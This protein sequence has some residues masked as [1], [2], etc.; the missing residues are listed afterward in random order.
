M[1]NLIDDF[2][3][4][5]K[6]ALD[7]AVKPVPWEPADSLPFFLR[8][9]YRFYTFPLSDVHCLLMAAREQQEQTP[10][11]VRKHL[12]QVRKHCDAEVI[13]LHPLVSAYNRKRLIEHK[14]PFVV[15]GNQMYLPMLGFD[16]REHF[17]KSRSSGSVLSPA[18]QTLVLHGL[19]NENEKTFT[20]SSVAAG[21]GYTAMTLTR[22][23]NEL[24]SVGLAEVFLQGRE[25]MLR[26][27]WTKRELWENAKAFMRSPVRK[28]TYI[29]PPQQAWPGLTAG[30]TALAHYTLL[31]PPANP[32]YA[33]GAADFKSLK[34]RRGFTEI[35]G[36]KEPEICEIEIWSYP[37]DLFSKGKV[38]D[39]FSL[40]LSLR[41][42]EDERVEAALEEM[43]EA[44]AW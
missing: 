18:T 26:F 37:P 3:R 33:M 4:Y 44:I 34:Q 24:E 10:A 20:P 21:L 36:P 5:L 32:V 16:L 28:R 6:E 9:L 7:V 17:R 29:K 25:R 19:F 42:S 8:D 13:Y 11:I 40:Y 41:K 12:E 27:K 1:E 35:D 15:P 22:A 39:R 30:L 14:V 23:F 43:M 38:V 2:E 31:A